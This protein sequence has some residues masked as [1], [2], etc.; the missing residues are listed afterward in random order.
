MLNSRFD[1][2]AHV[3][4]PDCGKSG[5][6]VTLRVLDDSRRFAT[7]M[8]EVDPHDAEPVAWVNVFL[9]DA[10]GEPDGDEF[11]AR[12]DYGNNELRTAFIDAGAGRSEL[13]HE[14]S[15]D[16]ALAHPRKQD[17]FDVIGCAF[18]DATLNRFLI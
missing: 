14:L 9:S 5:V 11:A 8:I 6:I 10:A 13:S 4:C 1:T 3:H 16:A 15:R 18:K 17:V 7:A 2:Q 12:V